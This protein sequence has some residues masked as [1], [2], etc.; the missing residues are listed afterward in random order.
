MLRGAR[1]GSLPDLKKCTTKPQPP[2]SPLARE[3]IR[4]LDSSTICKADA[5]YNASFTHPSWGGKTCAFWDGLFLSMFDGDKLNW[6]DITPKELGCKKWN[7]NRMDLKAAGFAADINMALVLE[8]FAPGCCG[9]KAAKT[10]A[11]PPAPTQAVA[12]ADSKFF[13]K[14]TVTMPY[15]NAEFSR[16]KQIKYKAAIA[17]AAEVPIQNVDIVQVIEKGRRAG[18]IDVET[19]VHPQFVCRRGRVR[20]ILSGV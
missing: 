18:R 6:A 7:H 17:T 20:L 5:D 10:G 8:K 1:Q 11:C 14:L 19:K 3:Q 2:D 9:G 16:D 4:C 13:V 15:G 12:P